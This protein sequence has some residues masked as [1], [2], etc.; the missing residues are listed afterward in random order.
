MSAWRHLRAIVLLPG[1]VAVAVPG[2]ILLLGE[3]ADPGWGLGGAAGAAIVA[4]GVVLIA[5]G[6][7]LWAWTVRLFARV[8]EGTL[9]PWDPTRRMVAVGPYRHMRNP[10]ITGV[11]AVLA[12][13]ALVFGSTAI[14]IL[15]VAFLAVNQAWFVLVEEPGLE[16]RFGQEY[17][18]YR[19]RV[20][21]WI[22]SARR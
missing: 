16:R 9:A 2:L 5:A 13:E 10:M 1:M 15:A 17:R 14:A 22:P 11:L 3:G 7:S 12:G 18:S 4:I 8:G 19:E 21:R 6:A 20:P